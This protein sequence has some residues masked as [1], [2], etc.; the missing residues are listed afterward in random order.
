MRI[1]IM[2]LLF[3]IVALSGCSSDST[4]ATR[5][6]EHEIVELVSHRGA[7]YQV[8]GWDP[9]AVSEVGTTFEEVKR[10]LG[11]PQPVGDAPPDDAGGY[12]LIHD[13]ADGLYR[14]H[15]SPG[16]DR[17]TRA[18]EAVLKPVDTSEQPPERDR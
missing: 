7:C 8:A 16:W 11:P 18:F 1:Q 2:V 15:Y 4:T 12:Y 14:V 6:T 17:V 13:T 10:K 9:V 5:Q 3:C